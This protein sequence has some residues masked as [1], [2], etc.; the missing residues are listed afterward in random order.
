MT[1]GPGGQPRRLADLGQT[2]ARAGRSRRSR[3]SPCRRR[4]RPRPAAASAGRHQEQDGVVH[5]DAVRVELAR[6]DERVWRHVRVDQRAV[7]VVGPARWGVRRVRRLRLQADR[8]HWAASAGR[9]R[10]TRSESDHGPGEKDECGNR[11][12]IPPLMRGDPSRSTPR[13]RRRLSPGSRPPA[14][15]PTSRV[16]SK[17]TGRWSR[18]HGNTRSARSPAS[19]PRNRRSGPGSARSCAEALGRHRRHGTP[20][21]RVPTVG[22]DGRI[23]WSSLGPAEPGDR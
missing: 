17:A 14:S 8:R 22:T 20:S 12:R 18:P 15:G 3:S 6:D 5:L 11:S 21:R 4:R 9:R 2:G 10:S 23:R 7:V 1:G 13:R 16:T 19:G